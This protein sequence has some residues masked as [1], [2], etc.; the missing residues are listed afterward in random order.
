[1]SFL[2]ASLIMVMLSMGV[3]LVVAPLGNG[4]PR[5]TASVILL[6]VAIPAFVTGLYAFLGSPGEV[7]AR[8]GQL[9]HIQAGTNYAA[10]SRPGK[11]VPSVA[12]LIDGLKEK[13]EREPDDADGWL[14]LARSY[15]HLGRLEEASLAYSRARTLGKTRMKNVNGSVPVLRGHVSLAPEAADRVSPGDTIFIFAKESPEVRMPVAAIRKPAADLPM[16]FELTDEQAMVSGTK[17]SD[18]EKLFVTARVSRSGLATDTL[19]G[20]EAWSDPVSPIEGGEIQLQIATEA[21]LGEYG[22]E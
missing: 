22:N 1:M 17:L 14:L 16:D 9:R 8:S 7:R 4:N 15:E 11:A 6:A 21:K 19:D 18:F 5:F 20:L 2:F 13:L 12:S 3:Y 10:E